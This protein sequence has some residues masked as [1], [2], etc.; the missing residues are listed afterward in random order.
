MIA[1]DIHGSDPDGELTLEVISKASRFNRWMFKTIEPYCSGRILEIGSGIGNIS[2]FFL[3][4]GYSVA[5][6]DIRLPYV[7]HLKKSFSR[8]P[9][10]IDIY[11]LDLVDPDFLKKFGS[12]KGMF[13]TVFSLNVIEHIENDLFDVIGRC[14][15][16]IF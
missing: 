3:E 13:E 15:F 8:Y 14:L 4:S 6:S 12:M 16:N 11:Q 2:K 7:D 5:L 10:L 9:Q 1:P